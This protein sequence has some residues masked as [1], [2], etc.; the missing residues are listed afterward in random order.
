MC[1]FAP[2]GT[3]GEV[4]EN[5]HQEDKKAPPWGTSK[6]YEGERPAYLALQGPGAFVQKKDPR[7]ASVLLSRIYRKMSSPGKK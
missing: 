6:P 1:F 2:G 3:T 4:S 7:P 5:C